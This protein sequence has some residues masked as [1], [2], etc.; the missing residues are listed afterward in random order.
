[1]KYLNNFNY[2]NLIILFGAFGCLLAVSFKGL[3]YAAAPLPKP[4][5]E[6]PLLA[7]KVSQGVL[8]PVEDRLPLI[9][10]VLPVYEEIGQYGGKLRR[11]YTGLSD[12]WGLT[13]IIEER[14]IEFYMPDAD[15]ITLKPNWADKFEISPDA[16]EYLF[17][18]REGLRWSDGVKVTT[19]DVRFWY[20]DIF[21]NKELVP[22][23]P[24]HL[25]V[26]GKSLEIQIID[27]YTFKVKFVAPY[28]FF[29]EI[30]AKR[31]TTLTTV[32]LHGTTFI[33][34]FH[35]LKSF[36][37]AY[38]SLQ[39]LQKAV[40]DIGVAKWTDLWGA[41]GPITSWWLNPKLP[42]ITAWKI[43]TPPPAQ[44]VVMERNPFYFAVDPAGNQL[45]YID[46]VV[47]T[48]LKHP[49]DLS[50][51]AAQGQLDL[52]DRH[53]RG[54]DYT[55]LKLNETQG[56]YRIMPWI[57][58]GAGLFLNVNTNN[59][60]L[61]DLF[62]KLKFRKALSISLNRPEIQEM[63]FNGLGKICQAG[64][65]S[66]SPHYDSELAT[67]WTR[68]DPK[69]ANTLLDELGLNGRDSEGFRTGRDGRAIELNM[70]YPGY[71]Y[72]DLLPELIRGYWWDIGLKTNWEIVDRSTLE[73]KV[74]QNN[75]EGFIYLYSRNLV[76]PADPNFF[77]G[78]VSDGTWMP[79]WGKW[80]VSGGEKGLEPPSHH[81]IRQV[82]ANWDKAK[83]APNKTKADAY[84]QKIIDIH[85]ENIW[86]IGILGELPVPVIVN[87]KLGN[88]P[89]FGMAVDDLRGTGIAQPA[90]LFFKKQ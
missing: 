33:M 39:T 53:V 81:P 12:R 77:L 48:L 4:F 6:S 82:W 38:A 34:P 8:P 72:G 74:S 52:Q 20:E 43:K 9:P 70:T 80:F 65:M 16:S 44:Q 89:T 61:A 5:K 29:P 57:E 32:T 27:Q 37:P 23:I 24:E 40:A 41:N 17:H 50:L 86:V 68:Y 28:P 3:T 36:H 2:R 58:S 87:N 85:K 59:E 15:T 69:A 35:Y 49:E 67:K 60:P 47:H 76:I 79:R 18:I 10:R 7:K 54:D 46:E 71:L 75:V 73:T 14:I 83:T 88:V 1:M 25:K 84:I 26:A 78:T 66:A 22:I 45:P 90:Q 55:I 56:G 21:L 64:P 42:V 11:V 30:M 63:A 62:E 31:S 51:L 13:K 19:E